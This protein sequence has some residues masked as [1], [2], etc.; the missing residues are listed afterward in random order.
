[1]MM[2]NVVE[3]FYSIQGEGAQVGVPCVFIRLHGCNLAC[4]FCD[5][6]L[7]KGAYERLTFEAV[8]E[9]I[10]AYP[11][12]N[13]IITGGEPSLYDLRDFIAVLHSHMYRV[14]VETNGYNFAHIADADWITYSPKDWDAI[15]L[16]G[17]DEI[18][19]VVDMDASVEKIAAFQSDK[20]M[21]IQ[22]QNKPHAPD[23]SNVRFCLEFVMQHP[24]FTFSAQLHKFLGVE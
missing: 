7:H 3:I 23:M 22:P 6:E 24:Q 2:L 9:R 19:F 18:K 1:M 14:G 4:S 16:S 20:A 10:A 21:F 15:A 5:E 17:Y 12:R 11:S 8:L 13:V